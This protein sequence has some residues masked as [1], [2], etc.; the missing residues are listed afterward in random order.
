MSCR[1]VQYYAD[2]LQ[3]PD[4]QP[5]QLQLQRLTVNGIPMS[6]I[7]VVVVGVWVRPPGAGWKTELLCLAA[8]RPEAMH[9]EGLRPYCSD[10]SSQLLHV[11]RQCAVVTGGG[12]VEKL[13]PFMQAC[14]VAVHGADVRGAMQLCKPSQYLHVKM[15]M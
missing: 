15:S 4:L 6:A 13:V 14:G 1:Y 11:D 5:K 8:T 2:L 12:L 3:Q 10:Q 9:L 7:R